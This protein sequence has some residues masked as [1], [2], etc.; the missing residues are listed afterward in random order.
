M[1]YIILVDGKTGIALLK[2]KE[3][4]VNDPFG[5]LSSWND[6]NGEVNPCSWFGVGCVSGQVVSL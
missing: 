1:F 5:G 4:L 3:R 2:F 6:E